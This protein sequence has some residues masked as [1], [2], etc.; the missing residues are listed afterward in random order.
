MIDRK[1]TV[2]YNFILI[3]PINNRRFFVLESSQNDCTCS[4][5]L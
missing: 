5:H 3:A 1:K 2:D 4:A